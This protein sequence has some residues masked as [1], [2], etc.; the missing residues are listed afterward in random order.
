MSPAVHLNVYFAK[1]PLIFATVANTPFVFAIF[2]NITIYLSLLL[3]AKTPFFL[4]QQDD[5]LPAF[6]CHKTNDHIS[7]PIVYEY[8]PC[9]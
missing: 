3:F 5:R 8:Q 6:S 4:Q 7:T 1:T 9:K 2:W